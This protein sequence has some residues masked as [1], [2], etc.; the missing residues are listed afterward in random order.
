MKKS[1]TIQ[2]IYWKI[3][4]PYNYIYKIINATAACTHAQYKN[5]IQKNEV[6]KGRVNN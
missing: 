6:I 3:G 4:R 5:S 2:P 1:E